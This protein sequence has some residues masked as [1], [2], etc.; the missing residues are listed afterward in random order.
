MINPDHLAMLAAS[1]ITA[2]YAAKRGYETITQK[3]RLAQIKNVQAA[4]G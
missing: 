4:R 3:G 1:G 2:D